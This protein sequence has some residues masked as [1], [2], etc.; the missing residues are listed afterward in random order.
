MID[1]MMGSRRNGRL[2]IEPEREP[3]FRVRRTKSRPVPLDEPDPLQRDHVVVDA[4]IIAVEGL[5]KRL[6]RPCRAVPA[7]MP[8]QFEPL[9]T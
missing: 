9:R 8:E 7:D 4:A 5:G 6:H 3:D 2:V 1:R